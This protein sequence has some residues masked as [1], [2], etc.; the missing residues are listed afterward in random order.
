LKAKYEEE[1]NGQNCKGEA[2]DHPKLNAVYV[3]KSGPGNGLLWLNHKKSVFVRN[4][5]CT[6]I[7]NLK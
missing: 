1:E 6:E 5:W 4:K 2:N 3:G 7:D